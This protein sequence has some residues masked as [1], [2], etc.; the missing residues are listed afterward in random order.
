MSCKRLS[1]RWR[2][3]PAGLTAGIFFVFSST[4]A[5]AQDCPTGLSGKTGFVVQR[6]ELQKTEVFHVDD[7]IVRTVMRYNGATLLELTQH[8][9][10]FEL[11][12]LDRGVKTKYEPRT[13]LKSLFPLKPGRTVKAEFTSE[14]N[15]QRGTLSIELAVKGTDVVGIGP[16]KY[17]VLKIDRTISYDGGPARFV[18]TDYY[19]PELRLSLAKEWRG[20]SGGGTHTNKYDRI[21]SLKPGRAA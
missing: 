12:R 21:Y 18:D 11:D 3:L 5:A 8:Q 9:G 17:S 13:D 6:G 16:C 4:L 1:L 15:G 2:A 20:S 7:G 19:S 14:R 10:L